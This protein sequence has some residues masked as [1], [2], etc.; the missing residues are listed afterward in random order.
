[1]RPSRQPARADHASRHTPA[2]GPSSPRPAATRSRSS[3]SGAYF[4]F[5]G[6]VIEK[7]PGNSGGNVDIYGHHVELSANEIRLGQ[8]QGVYTDEDSHHAQILGNWIHDNGKGVIHQS[9]GIYL[10][11]DDHL[12]ANNVINDHVEGFG[13]QVYDKGDR[14]IVTGN[15]ITGAGH[16]GIVVG[17]SGGVSNVRVRNN[18]LRL[19]QPAGGSP[20][21]HP[22]R[23]ARVADHNVLFGNGYGP[24]KGGCSG[25]DRS[26]GNRTTDPLFANHGGRDLTSA[27]G[28]PRDRLRPAQL[29]AHHRLRRC[30]ADVRR[31]PR[32]GRVRTALELLT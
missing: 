25:L 3:S 11:G 29:V 23:R 12:V 32:G 27:T 1:M 7:A 26:G 15:T 20:T 6:F 9:H 13:I 24:I 16:S 5:R 8:D 28:Q 10:Q 17:G 31:R 2:S 18:V 21:T 4:R 30:A 22:A 19:Q 14:A